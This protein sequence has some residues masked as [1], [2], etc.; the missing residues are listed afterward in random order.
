M[1]TAAE[2]IKGLSPEE[3][4]RQARASVK[5]ISRQ[6]E[7]ESKGIGG[8]LL[9]PRAFQVPDEV[10]DDGWLAELNGSELKILIFIIRK[11][12]GWNKAD[13]GD[14]ISISQ[15]S[16]ATKL[17]KSAIIGAVA[18]LEAAHLILV[19]RGESSDGLRKT[20]FYKLSTREDYTK[21]Y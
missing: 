12:F 11:T 7:V 15:I 16:K 5:S 1:R 20:N 14:R 19:I 4:M 18:T 10:V 8:G 9:I 17:S 3:I 2:I 21:S 13:L 6:Q